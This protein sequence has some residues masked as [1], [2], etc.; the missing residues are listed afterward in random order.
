MPHEMLPEHIDGVDFLPGNDVEP[1]HTELF[2][3]NRQSRVTDPSV[4]VEYWLRSRVTEGFVEPPNCHN[5][6]SSPLEHKKTSI[7]SKFLRVSRKNPAAVEI[8]MSNR[9]IRS[10]VT[11]FASCRF[12]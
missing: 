7:L 9:Q 12:E 2:R 10:R 3:S 6:P 5:C 1:G 8:I 11:P 4:D